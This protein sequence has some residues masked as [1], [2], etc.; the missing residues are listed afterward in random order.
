MPSLSSTGTAS[1]LVLDADERFSRF[2]KVEWWDRS[3]MRS[4][5]V[6][7]AGAGALGNE[8]IKNLALLGI[9]HLAVADMDHVEISNLTR[10][11]LFRA[12]DAGQPKAECAVRAARD[13]YPDIDARALVGNIT[14]DLGLGWVRWA[15][16]VVV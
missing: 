16:V 5:R 10:S 9:G 12:S 7:V 4:A 6:L 1:P 14:A 8:V 2:D 3:R 13:L 11:P 15:D